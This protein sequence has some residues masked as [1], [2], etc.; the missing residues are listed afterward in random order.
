MAANPPTT[1]P[2]TPPAKPAE[3][4][5]AESKTAVTKAPESK[6]T[7][8]KPDRFQ[9]AMPT[10]PGV[11]QGSSKAAG[12]AGGMDTQL[13]LQIGG[14]AAAVVLIGILIYWRTMSRSR[15]AAKPSAD[16]DAADQAA[17]APPAPIPSAPAHDG[18]TVAATVDELSKPWDAKKF[19]FVNNLTEENIDAMVIRLPGGELWAFSLKVP[20]AQCELEY[21][22]DTGIIASQYRY[23]A[24]HPMVVSPCDHTVYDP[25]KVGPLGGNTWARGEIVQ[26]SA[27]RPPLSIDVKVSGNSILADSIEQ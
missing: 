7:G 25:A 19:T 5:P 6:P 8:N 2:T 17:P 22:T 1:P 26:G 27:L 14:I 3:A 16:S 9:A 4:K 23:K 24:S 20:F 10:I 18:P 13:L 12:G 21:L 15:G 11:S